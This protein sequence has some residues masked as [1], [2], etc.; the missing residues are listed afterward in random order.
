MQEAR[1]HQRQGRL[2]SAEAS[3]L[4][5]LQAWSSYPLP[6]AGLVRIHLKRG[7]GVEALRWAKRLIRLQPRRG[8]N[9]LLLGDAHAMTGAMSRARKAWSK[10][11]RYGNKIAARRLAASPEQ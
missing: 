7:E 3:Y 8:N 11:Q 9:Q 1:V 6:R 10:A 4:K 2:A 5:A